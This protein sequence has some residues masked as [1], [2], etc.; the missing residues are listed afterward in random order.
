[1]YAKITIMTDD[2]KEV[3]EY[4]T[5]PSNVRETGIRTT[6]SFEFDYVKLYASREEVYLARRSLNRSNLD[7][8]LL[9]LKEN[10]EKFADKLQFVSCDKCC[11]GCKAYCKEHNH[12]DKSCADTIE[13]W[14]HMPAPLI[15]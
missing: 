14:L 4:L 6:Y 13:E 7:E 3:G 11:V 12:G 15:P 10:P 1:M 5:Y 2:G 8:F 9:Y